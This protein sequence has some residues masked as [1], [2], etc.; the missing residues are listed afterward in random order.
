M[1]QP[2]IALTRLASQQLTGTNHTTPQEIVSWM[3]AMQAQDFPMA[4]WAIGI[5]LPGST[6]QRI[7]AAIN[8]GKILRIH[9]MRPT[10]HFVT[11]EDIYWLLELTAAQVKTAQSARD[12]QLELSAEVYAKSNQVIEKALSK[13]RLM[14]REELLAE[15]QKAGI[16][17]DQ[18]R[19][20]HLLA[21]AELDQIICSGPI[22]KGKPTYALLS[23]RAPKKVSL[24]KD[25]A[26]ARLAQKYF[27]SRC[28][29]TLQDFTWWS[30]LRATDAKLALD[31][32][33][34]DFF[35]ETIDGKTYYLPENFNLPHYKA[36]WVHLLPTY[37][38]YLV[39]YTDRGASVEAKYAKHMNEISNRGVFWPVIVMD[40]QVKGIWKR[41]I[42]QTSMQ[43][44][45]KPFAELSPAT[46]RRID[47]A[48][49]SYGTFTGKTAEVN[50]YE[51]SS[52]RELEDR[53]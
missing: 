10:W 30:G 43:I 2:D 14:R 9:V 45:I 31:L 5:R 22:Q 36:G 41:T 19:S 1:S 24:S 27:A 44:D 11:A 35:A 25:E 40:G 4:K 52:V 23:E 18:N 37:D 26:L 51:L 53:N 42:K 47:E 17:T 3:G 50:P 48:G 13:A 33:K 39:A 49:F 16:A 29:A 21:Q 20:A 34:G 7:E 12:R 32:V 8:D 38:E 15:L 6:E 46:K 28:P